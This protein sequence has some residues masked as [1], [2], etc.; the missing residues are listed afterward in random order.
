MCTFRTI[1]VIIA[2]FFLFP[3][4]GK[5]GICKSKYLLSVISRSCH[6]KSILRKLHLQFKSEPVPHDFHKTF[7]I[8]MGIPAVHQKLTF[9]KIKKA[10]ILRSIAAMAENPEMPEGCDLFIKE[11]EGLCPA[12]ED[13]FSFTEHHP[14]TGIERYHHR[15]GRRGSL[16]YIYESL[17]F[18][19]VNKTA[20]QMQK[21][22][23]SK[24]DKSLMGRLYRNI[25]ATLYCAFGKSRRLNQS[26]MSP[27]GLI[28]KKCRAVPVA[29]LCYSLN[30]RNNPFISRARYDNSR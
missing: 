28:Y 10:V 30:I 8:K 17:Y 20:F 21:S 1:P 5:K 26:K 24:T 22:G 23:L 29:Y 12:A 11:P 27:V 7:A 4:K 9:I 3:V 25:R 13:L 19:H 2:S 15:V 14:G 16:I 18:F 6:S